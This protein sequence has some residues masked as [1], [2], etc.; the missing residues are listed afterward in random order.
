MTNLSSKDVEKAKDDATKRLTKNQVL[1]SAAMVLYTE[2]VVRCLDENLR[3]CGEVIDSL[4]ESRKRDVVQMLFSLYSPWLTVQYWANRAPVALE[5]TNK[6]GETIKH[7]T[8]AALKADDR[9]APALKFKSNSLWEVLI[10]PH[11]MI[12]Y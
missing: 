10:M 4:E 2:T 7:V 12:S 8:A 5:T 3:P 11:H 6:A 1:K 9:E